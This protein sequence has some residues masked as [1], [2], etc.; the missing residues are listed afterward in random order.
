VE[1]LLGHPNLQS[2]RNAYFIHGNHPKKGTLSDMR[3]PTL[4]RRPSST[5]GS[6]WLARLRADFEREGWLAAISG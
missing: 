1:M 6:Y 3:E 2:E 5:C 4:V